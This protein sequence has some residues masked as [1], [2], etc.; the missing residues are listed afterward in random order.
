MSWFLDHIHKSSP[1]VLLRTASSPLLLP[2]GAVFDLLQ[3]DVSQQ[4]VQIVGNTFETLMLNVSLL[5]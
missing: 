3:M 5:S 1:E 4:H 2:T